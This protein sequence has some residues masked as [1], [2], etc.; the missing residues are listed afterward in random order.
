MNLK[1]IKKG[2]YY[3]YHHLNGSIFYAMEYS[4]NLNIPLFLN[5][6]KKDFKNLVSQLKEK[7]IKKDY[8]KI[9]KNINIIS[10]KDYLIFKKV[11]ILDYYSL[12]L[13]KK[14]YISKIIFYNYLNKIENA[15]LSKKILKNINIK[16]L[17]NITPA[18]STHLLLPNKLKK[19]KN[20]SIIKYINKNTTK[21]YSK[22]K[23]IKKINI[24]KYNTNLI[25]NNTNFDPSNRSIF[26]AKIRNNKYKII[27]T[28]GFPYNYRWLLN[29]KKEIKNIK[30]Y[31][32]SWS[33]KYKIL[34]S[35]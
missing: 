9:L 34:K 29:N 16:D 14:F 31:I 4:I 15:H 22:Y 25:Y 3:K 17:S 5:I 18:Y 10:D 6:R 28:P 7:Y 11:I 1:Y 19:H 26:E 2:I 8:L 35:I 12:S 13:Y 24:I 21:K 27:R 33:K 30:K 23:K 32:W 20:K